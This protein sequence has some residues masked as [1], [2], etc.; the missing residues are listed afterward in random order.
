M[1]LQE[2]LDD[3]GGLISHNPTSS[4]NG[5]R[6]G[7]NEGKGGLIETLLATKKDVIKLLYEEYL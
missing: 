7:I 4:E 3:K 6:R 2:A 1:C 5:N